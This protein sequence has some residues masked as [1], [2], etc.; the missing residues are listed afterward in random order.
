MSHPKIAI[1]GAGPGGC[2]LARLLHQ[3]S[4]PCTIFEGETSINYRS[5]GGTLDLRSTT[6][7]AA[8]KAAGLWEQFLQHARYDGESLLLTDK[9]LTTWLRRSPG[10]KDKHNNLEEAPEIDRTILRKI[11]IESVPA[12]YVKWGWK[13][14][15]VQMTASSGLELSFANGETLLDYDLVVGADGA[16]SKTRTFLS[17]D[18]PHYSGLGGWTMQITNAKERAPEAYKFVNRGS[19]FAFSDG[20]SLLGQQL[21]TG[22]IDVAHYGPYQ[23]DFTSNCGFDSGDLDASRKFILE[24][25]ND[26]APQLKQL[27]ESADEGPVWRNLYELPVGWTWPHKKGVTLLGDAA[28]LM[29]PFAGIGVNSAFYDAMMLAEQITACSKSGKPANLDS[30][31]VQYEKAMFENAHPAQALTEGSKNDMFF[32]PGAPRTAIESWILRRLKEK[33]PSWAHPL[34]AAFVHTGYW[35]YKRFV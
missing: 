31:I 10:T 4:I 5:Q 29:T 16:W 28:H 33:V 14:A 20:K 13:L 12:D 7:L 34:L 24:N 3:S 1:I 17:Q 26:W 32:T 22:T 27:V 35:I 2:M 25:L 9:D 15:S 11:L 23:E 21:G 6:G 8:V 18:K 30:Y 19:V